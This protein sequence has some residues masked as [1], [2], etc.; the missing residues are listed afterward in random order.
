MPLRRAL[1]IDPDRNTAAKYNFDASRV[2]MGYKPACEVVC[3]TASVIGR[4]RR[5]A[6]RYQ[7]AHC[8]GQG[9]GSQAGER[10][11]TKLFYAGVEGDLLTPAMMEPQSSHFWA[12]KPPGEDLYALSS[13]RADRP[14]PERRP[15]GLR[16]AAYDSLGKKIATYL[17]TKSIAAGVLLSRRCF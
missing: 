10:D 11:E 4:S 5:S 2:E 7:P 16:C 6:E 1:Y 17:W 3:P 15:R 12:E 8:Y 13:G 14:V 9:H